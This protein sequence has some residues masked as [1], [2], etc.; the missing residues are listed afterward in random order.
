MPTFCIV[1][2]ARTNGADT[3]TVTR[4]RTSNS[5]SVATGR[6]DAAGFVEPGETTEHLVALSD[7]DPR[8]INA[9]TASQNCHPPTGVTLSSM[10]RIRTV[11]HG[12]AMGISWAQTTEHADQRP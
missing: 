8:A 11:N 10:N 4:I 6:G 12:H 1:A 2:D 7:V 3:R 9:D 5:R